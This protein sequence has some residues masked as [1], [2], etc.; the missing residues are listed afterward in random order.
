MILKEQKSIITCRQN[1]SNHV[2]QH[3]LR[4]TT[5]GIRPTPLDLVSERI[6]QLRTDCCNF[7]LVCACI[8]ALAE[9]SD[10]YN[11]KE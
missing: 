1:R 2:L 7:K 3:D 4:S 6:E 5:G 9:L 8:L 10:N 11:Q